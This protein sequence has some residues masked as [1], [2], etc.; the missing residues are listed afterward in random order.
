MNVAFIRGKYLNNFEGQNYDFRRFADVH[1]VA[2]SSLRPIDS[3]VNFNL[4]KLPSLADLGV[5]AHI[6]RALSFVANRSI[7]DVQVL[8]GLERLVIGADIVHTADAHYYYSYQAALLR[9]QR[10]IGALISTSWETIP[11]NNESTL[12]KKKRKYF[13]M[14]HT[15]LFICHTQKARNTLIAEGVETSKIKV[16]RLGVNTDVFKPP[17]IY[18]TGPVQILFVGRLVKEKGI[19]DVY[20]AFRIIK[21]ELKSKSRLLIVGDGPLRS[22]VTKC[23]KKDGLENDVRFENRKYVEMPEVYRQ[24]SFLI[25]PSQKHPTWEEQYGM[26]FIEAMASGLPIITT[27]TGAI[28]EVVGPSGIYVT[29]NAQYEISEA[30]KLLIVDSSRRQKIGTMGRDRAIKHFDAQKFSENIYRLYRSLQPTK[31]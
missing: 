29:E 15:D 25:A 2:Y 4:I 6:G 3:N 8:F 10:K 11:F 22:Y 24:S 26:V 23:I 7:G 27:R 17:L 18:P 21:N 12:Q 13:V 1:F 31:P 14:K 9:K 30:M 19:L 16:L 5:S 20:N 28:E